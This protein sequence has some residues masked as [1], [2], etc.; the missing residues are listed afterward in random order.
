LSCNLLLIE[1]DAL[2]QRNL[3]IFLKQFGHKVYGASSGEAALD[4]IAQ[5]NFDV[6]IS[7][8]RLS[9]Q[10]SG[11]DVLKHFAKIFPGKRLILV[12]AFGSDDIRSEAEALGA[13]YYEKP[14]SLNELRSSVES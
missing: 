1:D 12:T 11:L 9:G 4:L 6:L 7:D 13:F 2:S 8:L 10:L 14:I 5:I 3:T